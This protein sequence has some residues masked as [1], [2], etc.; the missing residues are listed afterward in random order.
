MNWPK[1]IEK[2]YVI[3]HSEKEKD[4]YDRL[5]QHFKDVKIP[6]QVIQYWTPLWSDQLTNELIFNVTDPFLQR[7]VRPFSFK[8]RNLSKGEISLTLNIFTAMRDASERNYSNIIILE[9]DV[10]LRDDFV[11]RLHQ[12]LKDVKENRK[13]WGYISLS[14]GVGSRPQNVNRSYFVETKTYDPPHNCVFRCTDSM[15]FS[16]SYAILVP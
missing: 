9:S 7:P 12:I 16:L 13:E 3:C 11:E 1:T 5:V 2:I 15:L 6:E 10:F 4:R 8:S 14:E